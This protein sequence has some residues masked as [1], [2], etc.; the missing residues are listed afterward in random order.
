MLDKLTHP[1]H[2]TSKL[3]IRMRGLMIVG[4]RPSLGAEGVPRRIHRKRA[5][6]Q[7][8]KRSPQ[9]RSMVWPMQLAGVILAEFRS[10]GCGECAQDRWAGKEEDCLRPLGVARGLIRELLWERIWAHWSWL[11]TERE[12][13]FVDLEYGDGVGYGR[14]GVIRFLGMCIHRSVGAGDRPTGSGEV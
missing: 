12:N 4:T 6:L 1:E 10:H 7:Q 3:G 13:S 8:L 9:K 2:A 5:S 11:K 14:V